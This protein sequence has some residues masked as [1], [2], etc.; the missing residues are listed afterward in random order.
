M[1]ALGKLLDKDTVSIVV[2]VF[3]DKKHFELNGGKHFSK[4]ICSSFLLKCNF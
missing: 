1:Y 4:S 3:V 2:L